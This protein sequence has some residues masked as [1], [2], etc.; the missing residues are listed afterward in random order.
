GDVDVRGR[1]TVERG[2]ADAVESGH[3]D[4]VDCGVGCGPA[5]GRAGRDIEVAGGFQPVVPGDLLGRRIGG[6]GL[7]ER[8]CRL[9]TGDGNRGGAEVVESRVLARADARG[10]GT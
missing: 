3:A 6:K 2:D 9:S 5:D 7:A 10:A 8:R 1:V 4:A